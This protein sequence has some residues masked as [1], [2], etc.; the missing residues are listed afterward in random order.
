MQVCGTTLYAK[1]AL[2][3]AL[4]FLLAGE[5]RN[6]AKFTRLTCFQRYGVALL[7]DIYEPAGLKQ[8][9]H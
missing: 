3:C 6:R 7:A 2:E 9:S 8:S 5:E 1:S 4:V